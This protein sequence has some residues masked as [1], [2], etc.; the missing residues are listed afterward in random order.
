ML[1]HESTVTFF[2]KNLPGRN[3]KVEVRLE[4]GFG[5]NLLE[6]LRH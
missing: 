5:L 1:P 4:I 3:K 2:K 6:V